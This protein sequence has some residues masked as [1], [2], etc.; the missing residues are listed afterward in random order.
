M[1]KGIENPE[2]EEL[3]N[4]IFSPLLLLLLLLLFLN[5]IICFLKVVVLFLIGFHRLPY[6]IMYLNIL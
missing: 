6:L 5:L 3:V 2:K 1:P 4:K